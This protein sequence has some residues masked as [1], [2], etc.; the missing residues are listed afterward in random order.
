MACAWR[1]IIIECVGSQA[2]DKAGI[3]AEVEGNQSWCIVYVCFVQIMARG[4]GSHK[5]VGSGTASC[6]VELTLGSQRR[7]APQD[8]MNRKIYLELS[9][10][11]PVAMI[12]WEPLTGWQ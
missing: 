8:R 5:N 1:L 10:P 9:L 6:V 3:I 7:Q 11:G 2:S 12:S 4:D